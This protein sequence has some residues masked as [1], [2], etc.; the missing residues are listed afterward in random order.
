MPEVLAKI[1]SRLDVKW[2]LRHTEELWRREL[3]QT[4]RHY[5]EAATYVEELMRDVGLARVERLTFPADGE[6]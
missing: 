5:R 1:E 2:M 3:G 4:F 6:S